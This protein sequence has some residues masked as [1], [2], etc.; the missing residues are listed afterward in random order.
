MQNTSTEEKLELVINQPYPVPFTKN[1]VY[2]ELFVESNLIEIAKDNISKEDLKAF[3]NGE[4]HLGL[5]EDHLI[6]VVNL[7]F[8]NSK[9]K[10]QI[11]ISFE[12]DVRKIPHQMLVLPEFENGQGLGI[13]LNVIDSAT[14]ILVVGRGFSFHPTPSRFLAEVALNQLNHQ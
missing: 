1:S 4:I 14:G 9:G 11:T 12:F 3:K 2:T 5:D 6:P 13:N 10:V 7:A 8:L